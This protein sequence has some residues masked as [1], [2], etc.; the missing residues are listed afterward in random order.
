MNIFSKGN[1]RAK[2]STCTAASARSD[3]NARS[4]VLLRLSDRAY[5]FVCGRDIPGGTHVADCLDR[6]CKGR[7]KTGDRALCE[8]VETRVCDVRTGFSGGV[9]VDAGEGKTGDEG[10]CAG[11][12]H[13]AVR[14]VVGS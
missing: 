1:A 6:C 9:A 7:E 4:R 3:A 11:A 14:A 10:R 5:A 13:F 12:S 2:G 8:R